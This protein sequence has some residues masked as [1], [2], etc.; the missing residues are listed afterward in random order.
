MLK[1]QRSGQEGRWFTTSR[2]HKPSRRRSAVVANFGHAA[3]ERLED[4]TL[5]ASFTV[6]TF[7][8]TND[9]DP[10]DGLALDAN[11]M[12]S[13]RAAIEESEA[14][15]GPDAISIPVAGVYPVGTSHVI[16]DDLTITGLDANM[17]ILDGGGADRVF[18][19][20][21]STVAISGLTVSGGVADPLGGGGIAN[22]GGDLTLHAVRLTDN[23]ALS[24]G[25]GGGLTF[26]PNFAMGSSPG[27]LTI[28]NSLID[29]NDANRGGGVSVENGAGDASIINSTIS[30]NTSTTDGGGIFYYQNETSLVLRN[31]T[32]TGNRVTPDAPG[33][34]IGGGLYV[35]AFPG[36][37][38][39]LPVL[40]NTIV[41]GNTSG[42]ATIA[43][44]D[45][46]SSPAGIS[47][48]D[49]ASSFNLIG[50][51]DT[52]GGLMDGEDG[53]IVGVGGVGTRPTA[54]ILDTL[55]AD[56]GG[57]T[58]THALALDS[59]AIDAGSNAE[60]LDEDGFPL[61]SDQRG[62]VS[63]VR[64]GDGNGI[65]RVDI[66]AFE[67]PPG[68][69]GGVEDDF[70]DIVG[71]ADTGT[72]SMLASDGA[73]FK[74]DV[75]GIVSPSVDWDDFLTG[76]FNGD[77]LT[78][79]AGRSPSDGMW[80]VLL[81]LGGE[82]AAPAI[83]GTWTTSVTFSDFLVGDFNG[84][85]LDDVTARASTGTHVVGLSTGSGFMSSSFGAWSTIVDWENVLVGDVNADGLSD[86][87]GHASTGTLVAAISDGSSFA[88]SVFGT[89]STLVDWLD[90]FAGD[91][92]GDG[93]TDLIGHASTGT[94]SAAISTGTGFIIQKW[95]AL[96][97]LTVWNDMRI[98]DFNGDGRIDLVGR[99]TSGKV[100][101]AE[102][103]G[104]GFVI[105][106]WTGWSTLVD[107][108][109][110]V[111]GDF[112]DDGLDDVAGFADSGTW[113]VAVSD[114]VEF[115]TEVWGGWSLLVTWDNV[116]AGQFV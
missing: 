107:W 90:V 104:S 66:G 12:T 73:S 115:S 94:L 71:H 19:I 83:W 99:S 57:P 65:A 44:D 85:G 59:V 69:S 82:F 68:S 14:L 17:V 52:A 112:N 55:L 105:R 79:W 98:G 62:T 72:I 16:E 24:G 64:D 70:D 35:Q 114:G 50:D 29:N 61:T 116:S 18:T 110:V 76:D 109:E 51:A 89:W 81:G 39:P 26:A 30:L 34:Q 42:T 106:G 46:N 113:V 2:S 97:T 38:D 1:S 53:N 86:L 33:V 32:I 8:D 36:G 7:N 48:V 88:T 102:S 5:L 45:I 21:S 60:A 47:V 67:A 58:F 25:G 27:S 13:L 75:A 103:T 9:A 40:H 10:G 28:I 101:V 41:A 6:N 96:S 15:P 22:F 23:A 84:D 78:D 56:N 3:C 37:G 108:T 11:G 4:R 54:E 80:R 63:R 49:A 87:I 92:N 95:G 100:V 31:T 91:V 20:F 111:V 93:R 74:I 77:G 43:D